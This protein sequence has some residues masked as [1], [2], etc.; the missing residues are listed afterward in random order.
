[1]SE[2]SKYMVLIIQYKEK[3]ETV[4]KNLL[5]KSKEPINAEYGKVRCPY[6]GSDERIIS[7]LE[8]ILGLTERA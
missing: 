3:D 2:N 8:K 5:K 4:I 6:I 7:A 1:M